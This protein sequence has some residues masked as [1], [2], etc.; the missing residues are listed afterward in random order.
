MG[1][2]LVCL[3]QYLCGQLSGMQG[4]W[5]ALSSLLQLSIQQLIICSFFPTPGISAEVV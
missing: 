3:K 1:L 2:F 5:S 4:Q